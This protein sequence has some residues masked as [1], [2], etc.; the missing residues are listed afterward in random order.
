MSD[1]PRILVFA[2][3]R[4]SGYLAGRTL[5]ALQ[6]QGLTGEAVTGPPD[7]QLAET[8]L[9]AR[10][11]VWLLRAGAWPAGR[12][13][14]VAPPA[15]QTGRALC[16]V[17]AVVAGPGQEPATDAESRE[18]SRLQRECGGDLQ[19]LADLRER[20]PAPASIYLEAPAV[21]AVAGRIA[22]DAAWRTP[23]ARNSPSLLAASSATRPWTFI[24]PPACAWCNS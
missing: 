14:F 1:T 3:R 18:W 12:G 21:A 2:D 8:L 4:G 20:L 13:P 11:P 22:R 16:A 23:C 7:G 5:R 15:S 10:G 17:G 24:S 19:Q 9:A 6:A